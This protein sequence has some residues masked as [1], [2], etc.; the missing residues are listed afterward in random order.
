MLLLLSPAKT[1]DYERPLPPL[2]PSTP[3]YAARA[4]ELVGVL[5]EQDAGVV[6]R[7]AGHPGEGRAHAAAAAQD[8]VVVGG[9]AVGQQELDRRKPEGGARARER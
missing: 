5:R 4:L 9:A 2:A 6:G 7:P 3:K 1:L 8:V